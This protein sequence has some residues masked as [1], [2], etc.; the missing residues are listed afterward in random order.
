MLKINVSMHASFLFSC[1]SLE[2]DRYPALKKC[3]KSAYKRSNRIM[4]TCIIQPSSTGKIIQIFRAPSNTRPLT[5]YRCSQAKYKCLCRRKWNAQ[6]LPVHFRKH[7]VRRLLLVSTWNPYIQLCILKQNQCTS[8][9]CHCQCDNLG[10]IL[11]I[12]IAPL[13]WI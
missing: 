4:A 10:A 6:L 5:D 13:H 2:Y 1:K 3:T 7:F 8:H 9:A 12:S 11:V